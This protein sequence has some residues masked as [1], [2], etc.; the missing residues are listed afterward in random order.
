MKEKD[1]NFLEP[2]MNLLPWRKNRKMPIAK[3]KI[4]VQFDDDTIDV[5]YA[6]NFWLFW[7]HVKKWTYVK[8]VTIKRYC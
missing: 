5:D 7:S 3:E 1:L 6:I 8:D 2:I 4:V